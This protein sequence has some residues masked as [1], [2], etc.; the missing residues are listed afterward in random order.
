MTVDIFSALTIPLV[1]A[2]YFVV[3]FGPARAVATLRNEQ[4]R[5]FPVFFWPIV[6]CVIAYAG[7]IEFDD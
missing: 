3:G 4:I 2:F 1:C 6:L 5:L 7:A